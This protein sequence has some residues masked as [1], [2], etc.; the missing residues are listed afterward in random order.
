MAHFF[1][2]KILFLTARRFVN[3]TLYFMISGFFRNVKS[4]QSSMN[5]DKGLLSIEPIEHFFLI[6]KCFLGFLILAKNAIDSPF[7]L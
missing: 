1:L 3:K 2:K 5:G 7:L 4:I 6:K